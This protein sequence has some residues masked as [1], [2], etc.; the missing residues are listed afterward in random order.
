MSTITNRIS[1]FELLENN[2]DT[3]SSVEKSIWPASKKLNT[4]GGSK[5]MELLLEQMFTVVPWV[6]AG[7]LVHTKQNNKL[8]NDV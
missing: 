4:L 3:V 8:R 2:T 6:C 7:Y 5:V 1:C